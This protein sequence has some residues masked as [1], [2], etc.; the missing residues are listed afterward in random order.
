MRMCILTTDS[1][2]ISACASRLHATAHSAHAS[3]SGT[4]C[5]CGT[6]LEDSIFVPRNTSSIGGADS[7]PPS[8]KNKFEAPTLCDMSNLA[9][10]SAI[11]GMY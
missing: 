9:G 11:A 2:V 10:I 3:L 6:C 7:A 4:D 8:K 1:A 5:Y